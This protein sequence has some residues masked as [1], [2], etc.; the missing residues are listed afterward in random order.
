MCVASFLDLYVVVQLL[1]LVRCKP[2]RLVLKYVVGGALGPTLRWHARFASN[3]GAKAEL[4]SL[5]WEEDVYD[6]WTRRA[7]AI[8]Q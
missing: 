1:D 6:S 2:A 3:L 5:V 7:N 4:P 8:L